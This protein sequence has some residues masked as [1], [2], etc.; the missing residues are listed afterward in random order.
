MRFAFGTTPRVG[1]VLGRSGASAYYT[2]SLAQR[3]GENTHAVAKLM[4][5]LCL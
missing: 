1:L 5:L 2:Q 3:Y 4:L